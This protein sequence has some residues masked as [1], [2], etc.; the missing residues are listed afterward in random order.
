M[1]LINAIKLL[2]NIAI[3][4]TLLIPFILPAQ[5]VTE[6]DIQQLMQQWAKGKKAYEN[7]EYEQAANILE[8]TLARMNEYPEA[9]KTPFTY[10]LIE[11]YR[12][13]ALSFISLELT[14]KATKSFQQVLS[15]DPAFDIGETS[16]KIR[17]I[18]EAARAEL[19]VPGKVVIIHT[20]LKY[21]K[22]G[23]PLALRITIK[24]AVSQARLKYRNKTNGSYKK[25][26]LLDVGRSIFVG[27]IPEKITKKSQIIEYFFEATEAGS[28]QIASYGSAHRPL[29]VLLQNEPAE[30]TST[31]EIP[32]EPERSDF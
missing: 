20:P 28:G 2:L 16:P 13:L 12:F 6:K 3:I 23:Q 30:S 1:R 27:V 19:V 5:E 7:Y 14:E 22:P 18:F 29:S 26:E 21:S 11:G 8:P 25:I 10:E 17:K 31:P 4:L 9:E 32:E 15:L 24:G